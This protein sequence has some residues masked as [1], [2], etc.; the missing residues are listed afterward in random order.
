MKNDDKKFDFLT[1]L[2][3]AWIFP[4]FKKIIDLEEQITYYKFKGGKFG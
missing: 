2:L 4:I 3:S 1:V